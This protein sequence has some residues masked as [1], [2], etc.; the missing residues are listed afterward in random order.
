MG[1]I[2]FPTVLAT[3]PVGVLSSETPHIPERTEFSPTK[4]YSAAPCKG[5]VLHFTQRN[6][7]L[8]LGPPM[9]A[10]SRATP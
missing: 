2:I 8:N 7:P 6:L 5:K 3:G 4:I 9:W 10:K 1:K